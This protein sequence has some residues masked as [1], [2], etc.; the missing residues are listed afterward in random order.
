LKK[1]CTP[2]KQ[3]KL[4]REN[5]IYLS[6]KGILSRITTLSC[7]R[8]QLFNRLLDIDRVMTAEEIALIEKAA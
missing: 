4:G 8:K 1:S 3:G 5:A 7:Q 2:T 6:Y